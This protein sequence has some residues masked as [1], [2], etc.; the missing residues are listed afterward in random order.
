MT[1]HYRS[2]YF[3]I[4]YDDPLFLMSWK[5][6]GQEAQEACPSE[7]L[8]PS[9]TLRARS[10]RMIRSKNNK[11]ATVEPQNNW[12]CTFQVHINPSARSSG[13]PCTV[14][15]KSVILQ[16]S[17]AILRDSSQTGSLFKYLIFIDSL[18]ES[19]SGLYIPP[20]SRY[21]HRSNHSCSLDTC[22]TRIMPTAAQVLH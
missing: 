12:K 20:T 2:W 13:S 8:I 4:R 22:S 18:L 6:R 7:E 11:Q 16:I 21:S 3:I 14:M 10:I 19:S 17:A 15:Q 1:T 5:A 9:S